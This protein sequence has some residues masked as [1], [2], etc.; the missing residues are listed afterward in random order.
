VYR[1][2]LFQ[3]GATESLNT[4]TTGIGIALV[5]LANKH[6][7]NADIRIVFRYQWWMLCQIEEMSD[8]RLLNRSKPRNEE[9]KMI[10]SDNRALRVQQLVAML[11]TIPAVSRFL[12]CGR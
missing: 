1:F 10:T 6:F 5:D 9:I 4:L 3:N 11:T 8:V 12:Y 7:V 2:Q